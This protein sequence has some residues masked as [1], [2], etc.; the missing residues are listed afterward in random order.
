MKQRSIL[1]PFVLHCFSPRKKGEDIKH[2]KRG[3]RKSD[4]HN[5]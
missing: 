2:K 4:R 5:G 1:A 3:R